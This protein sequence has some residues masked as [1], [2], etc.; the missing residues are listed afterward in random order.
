MRIV[1]PLKH[2]SDGIIWYSFRQLD[3]FGFMKHWITSRHGGVSTD[4]Y[5]TLNLA[6]HLGDSLEAV[7]ENRKLVREKLCGG[8]PLFLLKQVHSDIVVEAAAG[9]AKPPEADALLL[10]KTGLT[11]GVLTA[12]C[13]PII[14]ADPATKVTAAVHAGRVGVFENIVGATI[15][16]LSAKYKSN[17]ANMIVAIG[18]G[19]KDCCYKLEEDIFEDRYKSFKRYYTLDGRLDMVSPVERQLIEE[20]VLGKNIIDSGICTSCSSGDF[21]SHRKQNGKAGRF[22]T[23]VK[24]VEE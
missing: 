14:I 2:Q 7:N 22:L 5:A 20:G 10:G 19:I 23:A 17:P 13:L 8:S 4:G 12:D 16:N 3:G 21:F 1:K 24:L 15:K 9:T 6:D 11:A 18:P